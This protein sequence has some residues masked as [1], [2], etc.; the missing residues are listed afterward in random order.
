MTTTTTENWIC[1]TCAYV[2]DEAEGDAAGLPPG[3]R[4]PEVPD[5]WTCPDCGAHKHDFDRMEPPR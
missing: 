1:R 3:T 4:W 5:D 2:Y